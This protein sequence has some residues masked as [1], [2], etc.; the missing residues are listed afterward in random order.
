MNF[1]GNKTNHKV[2]PRKL[3]EICKKC[4]EEIKNCKCN[5]NN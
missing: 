5:I 3:R 4:W 1:M 2:G